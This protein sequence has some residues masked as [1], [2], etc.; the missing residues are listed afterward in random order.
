VWA[1]TTGRI[2]AGGYN[3]MV[4]QWDGTLWATGENTHGQLG[5]GTTTNLS[6]FKQVFSGVAAVDAARN[7]TLVLRSDGTLWATGSN[8]YGQLGDGTTTD[9]STFAPVPVP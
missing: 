4:L 6:R 5:D 8:Y 2:A 1:V 3:T 9:R 7:H